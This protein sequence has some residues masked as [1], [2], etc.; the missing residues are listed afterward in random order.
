MRSQK[1]VPKIWQLWSYSRLL[2]NLVG[3]WQQKP[4]SKRLK[5]EWELRRL[6]Q[7]IGQGLLRDRWRHRITSQPLKSLLQR[8]NFVSESRLNSSI[9]S[10]SVLI[11]PFPSQHL[12]TA[13]DRTNCGELRDCFSPQDMPHVKTADPWTNRLWTMWIH[14]HSDL[15]VASTTVPHSLC[16]LNLWTCK[17]TLS[18]PS[19]PDLIVHW[20]R[21]NVYVSIVLG[22][23][24]QLI[25]FWLHSDSSG[26]GLLKF[27][28]WAFHLNNT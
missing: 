17:L 13:S 15:F 26:T 16:W 23:K 2:M 11:Q 27:P 8:N 10:T 20:W 25:W 9:S 12:R 21:V 24:L 3:W 14:L 19:H 1:F 4:P 6:D 22:D 28:L 7:S 18:L 5:E